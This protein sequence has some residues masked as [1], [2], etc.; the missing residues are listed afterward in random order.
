M[1]NFSIKE[2][3]IFII[4]GVTGLAAYKSSQ[5]YGF[6]FELIALPAL[7]LLKIDHEMKHESHITKETKITGILTLFG[8][9]VLTIAVFINYFLVNFFDF[10][11]YMVV[12]AIIPAVVY[13][14]LSEKK[15]LVKGPYHFEN[16]KAIKEFCEELGCK[17]E[18]VN[19]K[20]LMG[21]TIL[22]IRK[23]YLNE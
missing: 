23:K 5:I 13:S 6:P 18:E 8:I 14:F 21:E 22:F 1:D 11:V 15:Y 9:V 3:I 12:I 10:N 19:D 7:V 2:A 16:P 4:L 17:V 20:R